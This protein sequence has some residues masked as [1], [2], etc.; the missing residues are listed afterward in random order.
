MPG[1]AARHYNFQRV[2]RT[3]GYDPGKGKNAM[4]NNQF[5]KLN[6]LT[7]EKGRYYRKSLLCIFAALLAV[8]LLLSAL[9]LSFTKERIRSY[10]ERIDDIMLRHMQTS[11]EYLYDSAKKACNQIFAS[12]NAKLLLYSPAPQ[13]GNEIYEAIQRMAEIQSSLID[14]EG[15]IDSFSIYSGN[16][17]RLYSSKNGLNF[18]DVYLEQAIADGQINTQMPKLRTMLN[19]S[20]KLRRKVL[21]FSTTLSDDG[22]SISEGV[23][24]NIN[25]S[26]LQ[27]KLNTLLSKHNL[28]NECVLILNERGELVTFIGDTAFTQDA[29]ISELHERYNNAKRTS[30]VKENL[31]GCSC[32]VSTIPIARQNMLVVRV[33]HTDSVNQDYYGFL[34]IALLLVGG[35]MILSFLLAWVMTNILYKPIGG[36]WNKV[37]RLNGLQLSEK[38]EME[39]LNQAFDSIGDTQDA[40]RDSQKRLALYE[41]LSEIP[42]ETQ[43]AEAYAHLT[44]LEVDPQRPMTLVIVWID[45]DE[46]YDQSEYVLQLSEK[47][48]EGCQAETIRLDIRKMACIIQTENEG[49]RQVLLQKL[50]QICEQDMLWQTYSLSVSDLVPDLPHLTD[51][52]AQTVD[53]QQ[54][55]YF[56]ADRAVMTAA[57]IGIGG[58]DVWAE[59]ANIFSAE[60]KLLEAVRL[61]VGSVQIEGSLD[62]YISLLRNFEYTDM[63]VF[64]SH[65]LQSIRNLAM[66]V[67]AFRSLQIMPDLRGLDA[68]IFNTSNVYQLR[69]A[70]LRFMI[71]LS[72]ELRTDKEDKYTDLV[73]LIKE[74][75][76]TKYSDKG[77]CLATL[78]DM[79]SLSPNY[80]GRLFKERTGMSVSSYITDVR[81]S[82]A[83]KLIENSGLKMSTISDQVGFSNQSSFYKSF[84]QKYS[85]TPKDYTVSV[86][87]RSRDRN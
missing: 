82:Q 53:I 34:R 81:L 19:A 63:G 48:I 11:T 42:S 72:N 78:S 21:T 80:V 64:R 79:V 50:R 5:P 32:Y 9:I 67:N 25:V 40:L 36:L 35:C 60:E 54:R 27:E 44:N 74:I 66:Q 13:N 10:N 6:R 2:Q 65:L 71:E 7:R 58:A 83:A 20:G 17:K 1:I 23:F 3:A 26:W 18:E 73:K 15:F 69:Q 39:F 28:Q 8:I 47:V 75:I 59:Q 41:L 45:N 52:Y 87:S 84:K 22:Q 57:D 4:E 86:K 12:R 33:Q 14:V 24:V 31:A 68:A 70:I 56:C 61:C 51:A 46:M 76:E 37:S 38:D 85:V 30:L 55:R 29:F 16:A 62:E 43:E 77:L 49:A